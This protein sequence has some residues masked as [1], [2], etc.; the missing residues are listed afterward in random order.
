MDVTNAIPQSLRRSQT[1]YSTAEHDA[2]S[3][4]CDLLGDWNSSC[5]VSQWL[6]RPRN[7]VCIP[8]GCLEHLDR[9]NSAPKCDSGM[10]WFE[11]ITLGHTF[12]GPV[13]V[14]NL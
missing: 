5:R 14:D 3:M 1:L 2:C 4:C 12:T 10:F 11:V 8:S 6:L 9:T 13:C 7:V